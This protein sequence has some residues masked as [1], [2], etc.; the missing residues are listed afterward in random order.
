[1][2]YLLTGLLFQLPPPQNHYCSF[3]LV[4]ETDKKLVW[5]FYDDL[6]VISN[7]GKFGDRCP[8]ERLPEDKCPIQFVF[9]RARSKSLEMYL[10]NAIY[11]VFA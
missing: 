5:H 11:T 7:L 9:D 4:A 3:F 2:K 6:D 1:M 10:T 8:T